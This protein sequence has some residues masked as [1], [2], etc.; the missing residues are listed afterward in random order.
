MKDVQIQ[1]INRIYYQLYQGNHDECM[2]IAFESANQK[3]HT[4]RKQQDDCPEY[5]GHRK[6]DF[7]PVKIIV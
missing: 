7:V 1:Q 2:I 3:K 4:E 6:S 5:Q